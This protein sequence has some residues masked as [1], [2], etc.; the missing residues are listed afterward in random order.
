MARVVQVA[1]E[2]PNTVVRVVEA[3]AQPP[4]PTP[5]AGRCTAQAAVVLAAVWQRVRV[6]TD[7]L[8]A[9]LDFTP[10]APEVRQAPG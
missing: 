6:S 9:D 3:L 5:A 8:A 2:M 1:A 10:M 7:P 4:D